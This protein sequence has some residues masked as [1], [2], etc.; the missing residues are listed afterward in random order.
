VI[1]ATQVI[2]TPR[3][4]PA[5]RDFEQHVGAAIL[6][7]KLEELELPSCTRFLIGQIRSSLRDHQRFFQQVGLLRNREPII[8]PSVKRKLIT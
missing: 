3:E 1:T 7:L 5:S 2:A 6:E 4:I 8:P